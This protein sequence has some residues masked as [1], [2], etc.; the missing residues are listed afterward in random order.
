MCFK[1]IGK[2]CHKF[3]HLMRKWHFSFSAFLDS[4]N[5]GP[6]QASATMWAK[7]I[8]K[9]TY[10]S[11]QWATVGFSPPESRN[12][13][14][15][16]DDFVFR[17]R[18]RSFF[19]SNAHARFKPLIQVFATALSLSLQLADS[20]KSCDLTAEPVCVCA[21]VCSE[22]AHWIWDWFECK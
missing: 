17:E 6:P 2:A 19:R 13:F 12:S 7:G 3:P 1:E 5:S 20:L 16:K 8:I 9:P 22:Y 18:T 10:V 4:F 11:Q 14:D 15:K 21:C